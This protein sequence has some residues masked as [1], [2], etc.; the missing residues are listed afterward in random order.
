MDDE[1]ILRTLAVGGL[2]HDIG[3][4]RERAGLP[5]S[6]TGGKYTH[7]PHSQAFVREHRAAFGQPD[8]IEAFALAH[9]S[10]TLND[11]KVIA[12]ADRLASAE[13]LEGGDGS[14]GS[15]GRSQR[16]LV[17]LITTL[18][19]YKPDASHIPLGPLRFTRDALFPNNSE[20]SLRAYHT[21]WHEFDAEAR[22]IRRQDDVE[23]WLYLLQ[24]Y[25]WCMPASARPKEIPDVSLFDHARATAALAVCVGHAYGEDEHTLSHLL[26]HRPSDREVPVALLVRA[27]VRGIQAF[28]YSLTAKGAAKSLRGRSYYVGLVAEAVVRRI[29]QTLDL[30]ITQVLYS[31]GGHA[32]LLVPPTVGDKLK[33]V[34]DDLERALYVV[35]G[36]ELTVSLGWTTVTDADLRSGG[37]NRKWAEAAQSCEEHRAHPM[38]EQETEW[39]MQHVFAPRE[40]GG[41]TGRCEVCQAE[42]Q[43]EGDT[44]C[45]LCASF[46]DLGRLLREAK[47]VALEV[48]EPNT[49]PQRARSWHHALRELGLNVTVDGNRG[50]VFDLLSTDFLPGEPEPDCSYGFRPMVQ[51]FPMVDGELLEF[52]EIA[53]KA[54]GIKRL[55][56]LRM[57]VDNLG[58]VFKEGL[59]A[60]RATLSRMAALSSQIRW[61]YEGYLNTIC[62]E[63]P[64]KV[65]GLYSGG[66]DLFFVGCW[67]VMPAVAQKVRDEFHDY[68]GG[69]TNITVSA[70]ISLFPDKYPLYQ[71]ADD[72]ADSLDQ[73]K[74]RPGGKKNAITF[75]NR[76]IGWE[77]WPA[78]VAAKEQLEQLA[79]KE[80]PRAILQRLQT[81]H[82]MCE[83][84]KAHRK[85]P[86]QRWRWL[87]AY[88]LARMA[89]RYKS[90]RASL[91]AIGGQ[92][93]DESS[94]AR[95]ALAARWLQLEQRKRADGEEKATKTEGGER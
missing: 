52:G 27:D 7:E 93:Q 63:W 67:D 62:R 81:L 66:D 34:R 6:E 72:A 23:T 92:L 54:T 18:Y 74:N 4:F 75:L 15:A 29:L 20:P 26:S 50:T 57:D 33:Q 28:L 90:E 11:E 84:D 1:S 53:E 25:T 86:T 83:W 79:H 45:G 47:K 64:E 77:D 46:E 95:W 56:A 5:V 22:R 24:K 37:V 40:Q 12:I 48:V 13:R 35:H 30:P 94:L 70:G 43:G 32:Y 58:Q 31:G 88:M 89:E 36:G 49:T 61:F 60:Q 38:A 3:K 41:L 51:V 2:L 39:L 42:L 19:G 10:P 16:P 65:Y 91:E 14:S 9:H 8:R 21:L 71:A 87:A 78:V 55:G 73:S 82:A 76:T 44:K 59:G 80:G 68:C 85:T 17:S 69:N